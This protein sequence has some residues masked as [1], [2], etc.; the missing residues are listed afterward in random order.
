[1]LRVIVHCYSSLLEPLTGFL[2][3]ILLSFTSTYL[4]NHFD[5]LFCHCLKRDCPHHDA[6]TN[7]VGS[8]TQ[9]RQHCIKLHLRFPFGFYQIC[10]MH[11]WQFW[12]SA[13]PSEVSWELIFWLMLSSPGL[14]QSCLGWCPVLPYSFGITDWTELSVLKT[15]FHYLTPLY[16]SLPLQPWL[17]SVLLSLWGL[18]TYLLE[19]FHRIVVN[20]QIM[21]LYIGLKGLNLPQRI[22]VLFKKM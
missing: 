21:L 22:I 3:K 5:P 4:P 16:I 15:Q 11:D 8:V 6:A 2:F 13:V 17:S 1:M 20:M 10:G 14:G 7:M 12:I 19:D 9:I 18:F